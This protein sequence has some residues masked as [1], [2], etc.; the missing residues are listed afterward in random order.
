METN[1]QLSRQLLDQLR[2]TV[3]DLETVNPAV[4]LWRVTSLGL[5]GMV[6]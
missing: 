4:G 5:A 1:K 6:V 3:V 2:T